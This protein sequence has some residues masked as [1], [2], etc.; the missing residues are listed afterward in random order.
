V[1][2]QERNGDHNNKSLN[3]VFKIRAAPGG[4]RLVSGNDELGVGVAAHA[5]NGSGG[6][7]AYRVGIAAGVL[8][9]DGDG[10]IGTAHNGA[11]VI[12]RIGAAKVNNKAGVLGAA[13]KGDRGADLDAKGFVGL[14]VGNAR[15]RGGVSSL[16]A[17]DV[18]R[19]GRGSRAASISSR[20]NTC[21]IGSRADVTLDFFLRILTEDVTGQEKW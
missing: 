20:A 2:G 8:G 1:W 21:G 4:R 9:D 12:E 17:L 3:F 10:A 6:A 7:C 13:H 18:D 5:V 15:R 11:F 14:G 16:A 19:T